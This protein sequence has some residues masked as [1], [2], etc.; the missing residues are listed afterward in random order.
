[1]EVLKTGIIKELKLGLV[2]KIS[3]F[4]LDW[5][6]VRFSIEPIGTV[7]FLKLWLQLQTILQHFYK[8]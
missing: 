4:L 7:R 5:I 6:R 1:M 3:L 8:L 2:T